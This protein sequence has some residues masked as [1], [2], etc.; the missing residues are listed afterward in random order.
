MNFINYWKNNHF[1]KDNNLILEKINESK[2]ERII[3]INIKN[4]EIINIEK[5]KF[6]QKDKY[7][8]N[9]LIKFF[10]IILKNKKINDCFFLFILSENGH[11]NINFDFPFFSQ[12]KFYNS[13][14]LLY[15]D[16]FFLFD[17]TKKGIRG[18]NNNNI[19]NI[20]NNIQ[21]K[22]KKDNIIFRSNNR[23]YRFLENNFDKN[24][25]FYDINFRIKQNDFLNHKEQSEYK[26]SLA[27]Y[28]RYDTIYFNLLNNS[29]PFIVSVEDE[30]KNKYTRQTFYSYLIE[31]NK[32][33]IKLKPSQ[34]KDLSK[35]INNYNFNIILD[36]KKDLMKKLTY[37]NIV[38]FYENIFYEYS[39]LFKE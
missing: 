9:N 7:I 24:N 35:N 25:S 16:N 33:Y 30:E 27:L 15:P 5:I 11:F 20:N 13:N 23:K 19:N 18:V 8:L 2:L 26:Y 3:L 37:N 31:E 10:N 36:N 29:I 21:F 22:D 28:E 34:L 12:Q 1:L 17:Y 4:N 14:I 38:K 39:L 32:H 6:H